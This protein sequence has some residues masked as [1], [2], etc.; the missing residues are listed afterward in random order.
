MISGGLGSR[1][2]AAGVGPQPAFPISTIGFA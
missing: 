1:T 2:I